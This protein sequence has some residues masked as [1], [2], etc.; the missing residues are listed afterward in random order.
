MMATDVCGHWICAVTFDLWSTLLF[1]REGAS[2]KRADS[3]CRNLARALSTLGVRV[4]FEDVSAAIDETVSSLMTAWE[5]NRDIGHVEQIQLII[6]KVFKDSLR[7][8]REWM[9]RLVSAYNQSVHEVPPCLNTEALDVLEGLKNRG[10]YIGL[11]CNTG[12]TPG[13]M[14]REF[15]ANEGVAEYFDSMIFS[16][17]IGIRKPDPRIFRL[18]ARRMRVRPRGIVHIGDNLKADVWG[19]QKAGLKAI[20][21]SGQK[22]RDQMAESDPNSLLS[23]SRR[24][25][26][27]EGLTVVPDKTICSL[28]EL[29][30]ALVELERK[31]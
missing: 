6:R 16:E 12:L 14:L 11:I 9:N 17:E 30:S 24:L 4:S 29:A 20:Y 22:G 2:Q 21:L 7:L 26:K 5:K 27:L 23:L 18:A 31:M 3:R 8:K 25:D 10:M 15:L 13:I 19:A 28:S 1:E